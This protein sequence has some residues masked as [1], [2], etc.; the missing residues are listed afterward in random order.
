MIPEF[1]IDEDFLIPGKHTVSWS[2]FVE[3]FGYTEQRMDLINGLKRAALDLR[4]CGCSMIY[5]DGSFVTKKFIPNDIDVCWDM[6]GVD[7][8]RLEIVHPIFFDFS[9]AERNKKTNMDV[10]FFLP[11]GLKKAQ[12]NPFLI[13]FFKVKMENQKAFFK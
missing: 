5:V 11:N 13:F 3:A 10:N 6:T 1:A 8:Y 12:T 2:E 7:G 9:L 4:S